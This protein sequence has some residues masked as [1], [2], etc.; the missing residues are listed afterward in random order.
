M[1]EKHRKINGV[2]IVCDDPRFPEGKKCVMDEKQAE[3]VEKGIDWYINHIEDYLGGNVI[4]IEEVDMMGLT[5]FLR[6]TLLTMIESERKRADEAEKL[7]EENGNDCIR[8]QQYINCLEMDTVIPDLK[9]KLAEAEEKISELI[10]IGK[11]SVEK[12][13]EAEK[14][15]LELREIIRKKDEAL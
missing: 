3:S 15:V 12:R 7:A 4:G 11:R 8:L 10:T 2:C 6:S 1:K 14:K 9:A 13:I 5:V